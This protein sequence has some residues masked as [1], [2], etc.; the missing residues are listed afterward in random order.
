M[1]A[2]DTAVPAP[3]ADLEKQRDDKCIPVARGVMDAL[4]K[5][6]IPEDA[7]KEV[8]FNPV[9]LEIL[10]L[11]LDADLNVTTDQPYIDQLVLGALSGLN[12]TVQECTFLPLDD[13]RYGTI[14]RKIL[15][16]LV[17]ANVTLGAVTP[18]QSVADFVPVKEQI[19]ALF[20]EE[21]LNVMEVKYVMDNIFE[22]FG[23]VGTMVSESIVQSM[24]KAEAKQWGVEDLTEVTLQQL[25]K[26]LT[27]PA[28]L[29]AQPAALADQAV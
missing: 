27:M 19:N 7:S 23:K 5:L 22:A 15:E 2:P 17:S 6:M 16:I 10:K 14:Q 3:S 9:V 8:N 20:A 12:R 25:D 18:E 24:K 21:K 11:E 26:V 1:Q 4:A 28:A 29:P 13:I